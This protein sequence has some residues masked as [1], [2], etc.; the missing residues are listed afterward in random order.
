MTDLGQGIH[1]IRAGSTSWAPDDEVGGFMQVLFE[2]G[3]TAVGLWRP[4]DEDAV[5]G[6]LLSARETVVVLQGTVRIEIV[7]GPTIELAP[8][9]VASLPKGAEMS[10][11]PSRDF[12]KV[13][14]V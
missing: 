11:F 9:D 12:V 3:D 4:R 7:D 10:W 6:N 5:E 8:G 1:L 14:A 2:E 13:W